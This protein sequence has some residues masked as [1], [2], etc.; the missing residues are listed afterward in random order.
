MSFE[1]AAWAIKQ[2]T[3]TPVEKL[4]LITLADCYN[5]NNSRCDPSKAHIADI[6]LCSERYVSEAIASL[7]EQGFIS[8][9]RK[10]GRRSNY[11]INITPELSSPH[12]RT[13]FTTT[14]ELSSETPELSSPEPVRTSKLTSKIPVPD[15]INKK[16]WCDFL[17]MRGNKKNTEISLN[18]I[19]VKLTEFNS[20]GMDVNQVL[21]NSIMS[22]WTGVHPIRE[23]NKSNNNNQPPARILGR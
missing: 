21:D 16:M 11:S 20:K 22:S 18:R 10:T 4:V 9:D 14:P 15:F 19:I 13:E 6:A 1:V 8:V 3:K 17:E 7:V 5:K 23:F 2:K 12:P